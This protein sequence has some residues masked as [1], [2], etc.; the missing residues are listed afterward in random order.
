PGYA[1]ID[2]AEIVGAAGAVTAIERSQRFLVHARAACAARAITNVRF[3]E[4]DLAAESIP[5]VNADAS[6]C[7]W[8]A[9]FVTKPEALIQSLARALRAGGHAVF[10]EYG[11]Y[12]SWRMLPRCGSFEN[13]VAEVMASWRAGGGEPD[14]GLELPALLQSS[15]FDLVHVEPIVFVVGPGDFVWRWP[16][17]FLHSGVERLQSLGRVDQA[18]ADRIRRDFE[19]AERDPNSLMITPLVLE[20][21]ARRA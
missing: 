8:V 16:A 6:W 18:W 7:R 21:I 14:I 19:Q 17:A 1:T 13:F 4:A 10:H 11:D 5:E 20:I 15:G 2:L 9:A 12:A 3:I